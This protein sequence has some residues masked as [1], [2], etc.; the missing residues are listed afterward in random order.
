ME[1][2]DQLNIYKLNNYILNTEKINIHQSIPQ[3]S[4]EEKNHNYVRAESTERIKE[5]IEYDIL[6][7]RHGQERMEELL[8]FLVDAVCSNTDYTCIG[9]GRLPTEAVRERLLKLNASHIEYVFDCVDHTT[10][11]IRNIKNYLLTALYNA[12]ATIDN[13]YR[14]QVNHDLHGSG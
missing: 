8:T 10:T 3:I 1:N 14:A 7:S 6:C 9:M 2:P 13:Y 11:A 12:P 5:N 4:S